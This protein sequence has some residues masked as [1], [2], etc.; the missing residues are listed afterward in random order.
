MN[1]KINNGGEVK[2]MSV[3]RLAEIIKSQFDDFYIYF[4]GRI[5][6]LEVKIDN[7]EKRIDHLEKRIDGLEVRMDKLEMRINNLEVRIDK[8]EKRIDDIDIKLDDV[9]SR[10]GYKIDTM[11]LDKVGRDEH[12]KLVKKLTLKNV[13]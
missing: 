6:N 8:I 5:D 4:K 2:E 9:E 12:N 3:D 13:L 1:T 10:L 11:N 7:L